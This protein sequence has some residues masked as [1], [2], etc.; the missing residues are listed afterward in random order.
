MEIRDNA[1]KVYKDTAWVWFG[2]IFFIALEVWLIHVMLA[3]DDIWL[4]LVIG[5]SLILFITYFFDIKKNRNTI[6]VYPDF[7]QIEHA[8]KLNDAFMGVEEDIGTIEIQWPQI[9]RISSKSIRGAYHYYILIELQNG[10]CYRFA[11]FEPTKLF[12]KRQ[13][14]KYHE[15]YK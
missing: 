7:L 6:V 8:Q 11:V 5:V 1:V 15:Q 9:K 14:K 13:L 12:L 4:Y 2:V 10:K 3:S